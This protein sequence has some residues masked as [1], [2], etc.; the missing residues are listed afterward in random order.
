MFGRLA[1]VAALAALAGCAGIQPAGRNAERA[2][3][4]PAAAVQAEPPAPAPA[5]APV[6]APVAAPPA[7]RP[8]PATGDEE[9]IVPGQREQQVRPP[10]GD[11][12][13]V[14]QRR[15][16]VRNWDTC[17]LEAQGGRESDPTRPDLTSPED[18]CSRTLGMADRT[19]VPEWRRE[20]RR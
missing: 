12:R 5:A 19:A 3:P 18:Y 20:R 11:P 1:A 6:A 2:P 7:E 16:D 13:S 8:T 4:P 17:V 9:V 15:E 10:N 14:A